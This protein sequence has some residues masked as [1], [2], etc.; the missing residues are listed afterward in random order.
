MRHKEDGQWETE[1]DTVDEKESRAEAGHFF[2]FFSRLGKI[3]F[4]KT[5]K[6]LF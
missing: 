1:A 2:L 4:Y 6:V 3:F 5:S